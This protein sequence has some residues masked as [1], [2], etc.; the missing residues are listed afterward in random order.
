MALPNPGGVFP[1]PGVDLPG[2]NPS[3]NPLDYFNPFE[4]VL[5]NIRDMF[6]D[7]AGF[8]ERWVINPPRPVP[9][10]WQD[11]LYGNGL[12]F[13]QTLAVAVAMVM[14]LIAMFLNKKINSAG[15]AIFIAILIAAGGPLFFAA[16]D[17]A[18]AAGNQ[19]AGN[20]KD[21]YEPISQ[22][23]NGL[24]ALPDIVNP[25]GAIFGLGT[26]VFFGA[27]LVGIFIAYEVMIVGIL[28]FALIILALYP[29]GNWAERLANWMLSF[30]IVA[31]FAGQAAA[32]FW[33]EMGQLVLDKLPEGAGGNS[34][35]A[36]LVLDT[37]ILLAIGSQVMLIWGTQTAIV[38]AKGY[39][40]NNIRGRVETY[41]QQRQQVDVKAF[42]TSSRM[43]INPIVVAPVSPRS[44]AM[45]DSSSLR[46]G[47][48][49]AATKGHPVAATVAM[50]ATSR[51][52]P[53]AST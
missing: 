25:L 37:A 3:L 52:K 19:F 22:G 4:W 46:S 50:G 12:G 23:G 18:S 6:Q 8:I 29:L 27:F 5:D 49:V 35:V 31:L 38:K 32:I 44:T 11:Y 10:D 53:A 24:L 47:L 40:N 9:G 48:V 17:A 26:V 41:T 20:I 51:R 2:D 15:Q 36:T 43:S 16:A 45:P 33:L 14:V 42:D 1:L 13:A 34:F 30:L 21:L 39:F 7:V 28:F